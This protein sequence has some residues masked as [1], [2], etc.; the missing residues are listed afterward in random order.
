MRMPV[1]ARAVQVGQE[2]CS[3]QHV[4]WACEVCAVGRKSV[5]GRCCVVLFFVLCCVLC[6]VV[7]CCVVLC[8]VVLCCVVLCC[9][10]LCCVVLCCVVLCCVVL[11]WHDIAL[12]LCG[13][14]VALSSFVWCGAVWCAEGAVTMLW[15][16]AIPE[17]LGAEWHSTVLC[18][19]PAPS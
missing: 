13:I 2:A 7:L 10:V 8:C 12:R 5:V 14:C 9:V 11:T 1:C 6:C 19:P 18:T 16:I 17:A 15:A 4:C 3:G